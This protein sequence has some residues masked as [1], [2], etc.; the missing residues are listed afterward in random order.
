MIF[1]FWENQKLI[2]LFKLFWKLTIVRA[3]EERFI[4][5]LMIYGFTFIRI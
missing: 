1:Y 2:K 3:K 5:F 4:S